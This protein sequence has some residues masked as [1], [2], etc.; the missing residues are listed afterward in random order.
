MVANKVDL[1][2]TEE[3]FA[4]LQEKLDVPVLPV[5]ALNSDHTDELSQTL[6]EL[7]ESVQATKK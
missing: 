2:D 7:I 1:P 3:N 6:R 4:E 5:S